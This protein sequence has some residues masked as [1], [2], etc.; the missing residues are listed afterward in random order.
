MK[1]C[2]ATAVTESR[3]AF[4]KKSAKKV[5]SKVKRGCRGSHVLAAALFNA[6]LGWGVSFV[7][8]RVWYC[9][10]YAVRVMIELHLAIDNDNDD[11][12]DDDDDHHHDHLEKEIS[13]GMPL[14]NL[15]V[16]KCS[17]GMGEKLSSNYLL[18]TTE[19]NCTGRFVIYIFPLTEIA[20]QMLHGNGPIKRPHLWE[21]FFGK[22]DGFF[23]GHRRFTG[24]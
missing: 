10:A 5:P 24:A 8:G 9:L 6:R 17:C 11:D 21:W 23:S 16:E 22:D 13:N 14:S 2:F 4:A 15:K 1:D 20:Q 12:D 18:L 19:T 3:N 7:D